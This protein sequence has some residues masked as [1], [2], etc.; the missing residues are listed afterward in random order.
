MQNM[1]R[2][3]VIVTHDSDLAFNLC[4]RIIIINNG[5]IIADD[6]PQSILL[7]YDLIQKIGLKPVEVS[8]L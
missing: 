8:L 2:A 4:N 1:N 6:K 7:N 3:V 5:I